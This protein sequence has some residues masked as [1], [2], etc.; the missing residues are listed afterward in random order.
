[1]IDEITNG[2]TS[3]STSSNPT[4]TG[5]TTPSKKMNGYI[6]LDDGE[7]SVTRFYP[8]TKVENI[9]DFDELTDDIIDDAFSE[10]LEELGIT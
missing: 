1:M 4:T 9:E 3:G 5:N 8:K 10:V 7:G 6:D 2:N